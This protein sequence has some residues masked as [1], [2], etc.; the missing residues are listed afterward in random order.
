MLAVREQRLDA[1][2]C[3]LLAN[4]PQGLRGSEGDS[5]GRC[6]TMR[7]ERVDVTTRLE[8]VGGSEGDTQNFWIRRR[9]SKLFKK[10]NVPSFVTN[11][12]VVS[13]SAARNTLLIRLETGTARLCTRTR[14]SPAADV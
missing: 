1:C 13:I 4:L 3:E 6:G 5:C 10:T 7:E 12:I 8:N 14:L 11:A 9:Y 2:V